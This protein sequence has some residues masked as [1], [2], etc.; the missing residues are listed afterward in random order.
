M[1][2]RGDDVRAHAT[3]DDGD[4]ARKFKAM[5]S[6]HHESQ[7][8]I[9]FAVSRRTMTVGLIVLMGAFTFGAGLTSAN[10]SIMT[11]DEVMVRLE[12]RQIMLIDVRSPQE[13]R[14]T[15]IASG[16]RRVTIH[17]P[18]GLAGFIEAVKVAVGGDLE[19]AI[20]VICARGNRS[21]VAHRALTLAGFIRIVN[22]KE[23]MLGGPY[24]PGW[25]PRGLPME[26]CQNC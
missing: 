7:A 16:A 24:G 21:T 1:D 15:G 11:A 18:D 5:T 25:L 12:R 17:N 3:T 19:K 14:Q 13:W 4:I 20:A 9:G 8:G 6:P 26:A 10:D 2:R 22:L 23:G